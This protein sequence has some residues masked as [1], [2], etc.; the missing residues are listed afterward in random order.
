VFELVILAMIEE[1][2]DT[3]DTKVTW[4]D[5]ADAADI[6]K[7]ALSHFKKGTELKFPTLL[8]VAK[9][10]FESDYF[11][12]FKTWCL[13]L[14]QPMNIRYALEYLS[15]NKQV[16]ELE[17]LIQKIYNDYPTK[18]LLDW[19]NV[20]KI[21]LDYLKGGNLEVILDQLRMY[22]PKYPET[23]ILASV[24]EVYCKNKMREY[25]SMK[26][27]ISGLDLSISQIKEDYIKESFNTR[28]NEILSYVYLHK[29][30]N[31]NK[32][33]ECANKIIS[34]DLSAVL[35]ANAY[36]IVGM[37]YLYEDYDTCLG[38]VMK[39][40]E[41]LVKQERYSQVIVVDNNDFPFIK[42]VWRKH[43]KQPSTNDISEI[44]HFAALTGEKELASKLINKAIEEEGL[45]G[46]KLYYKALATGDKSLYMQSLIYFVSKKG[47]K[48]F[49]NLPYN[50]LKD[51]ETFKSM[52]DL[53]FNDT[54]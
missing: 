31:P 22:N 42:N 12:K 8:K 41:M 4:K 2:L 20:Y 34:S 54:I 24:I 25:T 38:N 40:R 13:S 35:S 23:R 29:E 18:E 37:S 7:S 51:D 36:Y 44:A 28:L 53:L 33:R 1:T 9:F 32:A 47:D 17:N 50:Q 15:L 10:I 43:T 26:S 14:N 27:I 19:A 5:I 46:F 48:F 21:L 11:L 45:S 52:A 3:L 30:N 39:Y 6:S 49:A 16:V